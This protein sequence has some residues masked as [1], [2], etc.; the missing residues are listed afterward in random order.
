MAKE[1][2][3]RGCHLLIAAYA[4]AEKDPVALQEALEEVQNSAVNLKAFGWG[5]IAMRRMSFAGQEGDDEGV[6][7]QVNEYK[8]KDLFTR[9]MREYEQNKGD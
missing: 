3:L 5:S 9:L 6:N 8:F 1:V 4:A 7:T 2:F